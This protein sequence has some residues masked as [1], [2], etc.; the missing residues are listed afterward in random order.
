MIAFG[1][2]TK[3]KIFCQILADIYEMPVVTLKNAS[4]ITALGAAIIGGV[5]V[6]IYD[7]FSIAEKL[8]QKDQIYYP[9]EKNKQIYEKKYA[10]F[11]KSY[12]SLKAIFQEMNE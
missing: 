1:G 2:L 3:D 4:H 9:N 11:K 6:G 8:A 10:I 5:A 12:G 7:D